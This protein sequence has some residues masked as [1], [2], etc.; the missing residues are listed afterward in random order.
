[1][2]ISRY[3]ETENLKAHCPFIYQLPLPNKGDFL[4]SWFSGNETAGD[5]CCIYMV[6]IKANDLTYSPSKMYKIAYHEGYAC[7]NPVMVQDPENPDKLLFFYSRR[8]PKP[9]YTQDNAE[10]FTK[11]IRIDLTTSD[12]I[13]STID[14]ENGWSEPTQLNCPISYFTKSEPICNLLPLYSHDNQNYLY[15]IITN[16]YHKLES[17]PDKRLCQAHIID[18]YN[19]SESARYHCYYRDRCAENIYMN[20]SNDLITWSFPEKTNLYNNN[21]GICMLYLG[22]NKYIGIAN[23]RLRLFR[24]PMTIFISTD[25]IQWKNVYDIERS[26]TTDGGIGLDYKE[27]SYPY[28]VLDRNTE[29]LIITYTHERSRIRFTVIA[30]DK[31]EAWFSDINNAYYC[32][33]VSRLI[34]E[35]YSTKTEQELKMIKYYLEVFSNLGIHEEE[36][37]DWK[38]DRIREY[39]WD[40]DSLEDQDKRRGVILLRNNYLKNVMFCLEYYGDQLTISTRMSQM[41]RYTI[42]LHNQRYKITKEDV[43]TFLNMPTKYRNVMIKYYVASLL[44]E[45][46]MIEIPDFGY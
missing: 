8:K 36:F 24:T 4:I 19:S 42:N 26:I 30:H 38:L 43:L 25:G 7:Q 12:Q 29:N 27:L 21:S 35:F 18:T 2:E 31:W 34:K 3:F 46:N 41:Y 13:R 9:H 40:Y 22:N 14:F 39:V 23:T 17:Y 20:T 44:T 15:N 1:M 45:D 28:M 6:Y 16:K 32:N 11:S 33:N 5:F 10:V 37:D